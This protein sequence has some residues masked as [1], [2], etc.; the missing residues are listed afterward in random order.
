MRKALEELHRLSAKEEALDAITVRVPKDTNKEI[1]GFCADNQGI[2]RAVVLR[3]C[4]AIGWEALRADL[5][6]A[7]ES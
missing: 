6:R 7:E 1:R 5:S 2:T 4:I 3:Q